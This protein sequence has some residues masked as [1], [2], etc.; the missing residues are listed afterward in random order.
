MKKFF[1]FIFPVV[2]FILIFFNMLYGHLIFDSFYDEDI[3]KYAIYVHLQ[4]EWNS[5]PGNILYDVTNVWSNPDSKS[6]VNVFYDSAESSEL[7]DYNSNQLQYQNQKSFVR[8]KHE[9]SNCE[10][11]WKPLLYRYVIDNVRNKIEILQGNQL[12]NDPYISKFPNDINENYDL[13]KQQELL[14][15]G[16]LQFI[17]VCTSKDSTSYEFAISMNDKNVGFDVFFVPSETELFHYISDSS[18]EYYKK[19]GCFAKN[20]LSF[21]G[22]CNDVGANS[23]LLIAI[24]DNL[25][26]SLTKVKISLHEKD[27]D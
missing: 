12:S 8:L 16:Y 22:S 26:M 27:T 13:K 7:F 17:P 25:S 11:N 6:T 24:P 5:Y 20:H 4:P 9:F 23:G 15:N 2:A 1:Y 14:K 21:S 18:F 3:N 10:S 19:Q